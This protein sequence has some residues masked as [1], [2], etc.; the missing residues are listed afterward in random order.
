MVKENENLQAETKNL[1]EELPRQIQ[2]AKDLSL[3]LKAQA[4]ALLRQTNKLE[5]QS[6]VLKTR[7]V[8]A[9]KARVTLEQIST[10]KKSVGDENL[11]NILSELD[12]IRE[13]Q[14]KK[15]TRLPVESDSHILSPSNQDRFNALLQQQITEMSPVIKNFQANSG[16]KL[17]DLDQKIAIAMAR[18]VEE[19]R[20]VV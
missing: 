5:K 17:V 3:N 20:L 19:E 12:I 13:E 8:N 9:G 14:A 10:S 6:T 4:A 1:Q 11:E 7:K 16:S 18:K 2:D 15:L